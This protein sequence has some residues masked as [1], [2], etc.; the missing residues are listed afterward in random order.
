[1]TEYCP[2]CDEGK[3]ISCQEKIQVSWLGIDG[4]ITS[5]HSQ[6]NSCGSEFA[7]ADDARQ[8][9]QFMLEFIE[10]VESRESNI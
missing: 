1:M 9:K 4:R 2:I 8:N 6:C 7:T 10:Q 3:I 5:M